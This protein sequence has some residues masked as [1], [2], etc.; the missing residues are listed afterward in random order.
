MEMSALPGQ[1]EPAFEI[2]DVCASV[3]KSGTRTSAVCTVIDWEETY[4]AEWSVAEG[5]Q[6]S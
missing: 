2:R 6:G 1:G 4:S 5:S 3:V